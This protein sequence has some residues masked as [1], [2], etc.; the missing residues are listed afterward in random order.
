MS[1]ISADVAELVAARAADR[2]EY[3]RMHQ[4]LQGATFHIEHIVPQSAGGSDDPENLCL[5][6]PSCN[7]HK[8]N[9]RSAPDP[10]TGREAALFDP[11][12]QQWG[13]HFMWDGYRVV[14]RTPTGRAT[15]TALEMNHSRRLRVREAEA[16]FDLF[17]PPTDNDLGWA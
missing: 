13:E 2:C 3:C 11:R 17:P 9:R 8:S 16:N 15:A 6:C 10:E 12:N 5:A 1:G 7:L 4:S 14:G